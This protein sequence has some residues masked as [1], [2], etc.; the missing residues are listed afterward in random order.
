MH[1]REWVLVIMAATLMAGCEGDEPGGDIVTDPP[2][3]SDDVHEEDC[4]C[5]E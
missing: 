2:G 4:G 3:A 1:I 5:P